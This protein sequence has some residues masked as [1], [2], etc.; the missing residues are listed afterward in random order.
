VAAR[1][2]DPRDGRAGLEE[3]DVLTLSET[4]VPTL[5]SAAAPVVAGDQMVLLLG[6]YRGDIWIRDIR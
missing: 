2:F 4:V 1:A 5:I 3:L 6:N